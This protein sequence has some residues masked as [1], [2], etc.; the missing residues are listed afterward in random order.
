MGINREGDGLSTWVLRGGPAMR[1]EG[2]W[3]VWYDISSDSRK[4]W[5]IGIGG[6]NHLNDDRISKRQN[7]WVELF[8]KPSNRFNLSLNPFFNI[9]KNNLQYVD[10]VEK[11]GEY[12]YILSRLDQNTFG[13]VFRLNYSI[14]PELSIQYYGQPY[15][16]AGEY[17]RFKR[18][19]NSRADKSE[20]RFLDFTGNEISYDAQAEEYQ[21]DEDGNGVVDYTFEL[22]DFS[23]K[24]FRSNLVIRWEYRSGSILYLVWSQAATV[25]DTY[26]DFSFNRDMK[27]LLNT[28]ADN[29][30]LIKLNY[31]FSL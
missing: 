31:W 18:V 24:Q 30:F 14:T 28:Y 9:N 19:T 5:Q 1:Y 7:I 20:D 29:I 12:R 22:P 8:L 3:N 21:V 13:L 17:T 26:G 4:S 27:N 11:E 16:S 15:I 2:G 23:F 6:F 10:T 25:E